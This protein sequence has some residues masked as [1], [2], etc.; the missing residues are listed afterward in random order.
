MGA[1]I[2]ALPTSATGPVASTRRPVAEPT[3]PPG[4]APATVGTMPVGVATTPRNRLL[5]RLSDPTPGEETSA[6]HAVLA[7]SAEPDSRQGHARSPRV[8]LAADDDP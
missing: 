5:A 8:R 6:T 3:N 4:S 7:S 2:A 1:C